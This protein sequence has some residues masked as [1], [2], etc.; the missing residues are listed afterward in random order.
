MLLIVLGE[1]HEDDEL[2]IVLG[3]SVHLH[4]DED[5]IYNDDILPRQIPR[6]AP[7]VLLQKK[8]KLLN[9]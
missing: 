7:V 1:H 5:L 2:I 9:I 4:S 8:T 6:K 3:E